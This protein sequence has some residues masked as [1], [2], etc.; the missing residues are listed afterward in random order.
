MSA[1]RPELVALLAA[2][3]DDLGRL[4]ARDLLAQERLVLVGDLLHLRLDL[5]EVLGRQLVVQVDVV[6]EARVRRRTDV[7]LGV[8]EEA[9]DRRRQDVR[10]RV[11][12]F[13]ERSHH[14][15]CET[16][17]ALGESQVRLSSGAPAVAVLAVQHRPAGGGEVLA[18]GVGG[19][20]VLGLLRR[21][22]PLRDG[23]GPPLARPPWPRPSRRT[24]EP[25]GRPRAR[26]RRPWRRASC[27]RN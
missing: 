4:L 12:E 26:R 13:F 2:G 3:P 27:R 11:A 7:E 16:W 15:E 24:R 14:G 17:P 9:Q 25:A 8:G 1:R 20:E 5:H 22:A 18:Q 23:A 21:P 19:R 6:V 10:G